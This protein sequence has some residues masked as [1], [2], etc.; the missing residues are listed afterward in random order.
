MGNFSGVAR[1]IIGGNIFI[2]SHSRTV[3][4]S[5]SKEINNAQHEYNIRVVR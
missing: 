3:K 2:Y 5:I 1:S 4:Q